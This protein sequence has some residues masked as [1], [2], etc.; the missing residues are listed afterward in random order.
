MCATCARVCIEFDGAAGSLRLAMVQ[1]EAMS[2]S[3]AAGLAELG[4]LVPLYCPASYPLGA[5]MCAVRSQLA[6]AGSA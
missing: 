2:F 5:A 6:F 1:L 4:L 3:G